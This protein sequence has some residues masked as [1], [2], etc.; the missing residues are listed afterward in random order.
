MYSLK[1][2]IRRLF[3]DKAFSLINTFGLVIGISSFLVLFIHVSNEKSFDEHF[4]DH[5]NIYR[6][7]SVPGGLDN[8]A[9]ARS[10]GIVHTAVKEIPEVEQA[11]QFSHCNGGTI[12]IGETSFSQDNIMSVDKAFMQLF[13]VEPVVGNL[14]EI[15]S[16]NTVFVT[17]DFARKY[18]G[19]LNPVGQIIKIE[20]LQYTRDLGDYEIRGVVKNTHPK[21]HFRYELLISQK[22]GLQERFASLP[23]RK[24]Q[25]TYNYFK[26]KN[27]ADPKLVAAKV[28]AFYDGSSLKTTPGPQEYDFALFPMDDIHL[29]SDYRFEL[30][31]SSS[32]I[33][34][35]LFTL[36]SFVIL[37]ISLLNFTNLSVARLIKRSKEL[38]LKR[39]I[40]AGK[41]QILWQ[42]LTEV[43]I[44][45]L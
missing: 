37:M 21:T 23:S 41:R 19:N 36:V 7:T 20:A 16:P 18:Y 32:K 35:G 6:V 4:T 33:N 44:V 9:W 3:K 1:I 29:K 10:I 17:E 26:L 5:E 31:E 15:S 39:S 43:F 27:D 24:I 13:E 2:T 12:R 42:V 28:K 22:G 45:G 38:G 40:G 14:S 25:W 30:H 34:I 11:T 8:A